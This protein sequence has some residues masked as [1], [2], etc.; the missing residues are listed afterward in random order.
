MRV[1]TIWHLYAQ[2]L[3][4]GIKI[5]ETR[6]WKTKYRGPVAIHTSARPMSAEDRALAQEFGVE[7]IKRGYIAAIADLTECILMDEAFIAA[8]TE[9]EHRLGCWKKGNYAWKFENFR[10]PE[11]DIYLSGRQGLWTVDWDL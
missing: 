1:L 3:A 8:Q 7:G 9:Q 5:Y 6:T 4:D 10:K 2:A 11:R